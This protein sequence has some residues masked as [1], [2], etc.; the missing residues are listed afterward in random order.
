MTR[1][2]LTTPQIKWFLGRGVTIDALINPAAILR[3]DGNGCCYFQDEDVFWH[4]KTGELHGG[5]W[6]LGEDAIEDP[7]TYCFDGALRIYATPL[8]W[9]LAGREGGIVVVDWR[10]AYE[11]LRR[12]PR[13]CVSPAVADKY[14]SHVK[15]PRLPVMSVAA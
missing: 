6:C 11:N 7:G 15:H 13:V 12:V 4:P 5:S 3:A 1:A 2:G 14:R 10:D 8:E 9:L